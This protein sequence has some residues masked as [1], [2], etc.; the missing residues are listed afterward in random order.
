MRMSFIRSFLAAASIIA[1]LAGGL[2]GAQP[3]M[4]QD[5]VAVLDAGSFI[6]VEV[7]EAP[8]GEVLDRLRE[9]LG[10][11]ITNTDMLDLNRRIEGRRSAPVMEVMQWLVP[12]A[13]VLLLYAAQ[14]PDDN[15]PAR[16]ERVTFFARGTAAPGIGIN[17]DTLA[18]RPGG[19]QAPVGGAGAA[20]AAG[21][22]GGVGTQE[23]LRTDGSK[24]E[25]SGGSPAA[26]ARST[27][28]VA[29]ADQLQAMSPSWQL[30][31]QQNAYRVGTTE[32]P[33]NFLRPHNDVAQTTIEQQQQRSQALAVEQLR[34]LMGA[35]RNACTGT[36]C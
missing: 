18:A 6:V 8:L 9:R 3:A 16:L 5:R 25:D 24:P 28:G 22:P 29:V 34:A 20:V 26:A 15:R 23:N 4:A 31:Q 36:V 7:H 12:D 13:N 32:P 27:D 11:T 2:P 14:R 1:L 33:P 19:T 35:M 21:R 17:P 10:V 30:Q